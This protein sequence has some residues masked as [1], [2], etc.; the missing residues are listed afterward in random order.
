MKY[1][2]KVLLADVAGIYKFILTFETKFL[3]NVSIMILFPD[4]SL[5]Q[6]MTE[7]KDIALMCTL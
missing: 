5:Q 6:R 3:I 1:A 2:V 7:K 4:F